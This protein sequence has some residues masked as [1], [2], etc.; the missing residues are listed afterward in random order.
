M[1]RIEPSFNIIMFTT[2]TKSTNHLATVLVQHIMPL[3][4]PL[5]AIS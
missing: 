4:V 2:S 3:S 5:A 1:K